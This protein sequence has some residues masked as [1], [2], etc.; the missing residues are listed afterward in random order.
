MPTQTLEPPT[1]PTAPQAPT[2]VTRGHGFLEHTL[3]KLRARKANALIPEPLRQGRILDIGCGSFPYFL[4]TT[5]FAEKHGVDK[6]VN[7]HDA[8]PGVQLRNFD[9]YASDRLPYESG[10]FDAVTML[11]VFEHI[12]VD[13][14]VMLITDIHRVLKPRGVYVMT[15]PAGWTG[16]VLDAL[17]TVGAVSKEEIDEHEDSYSPAKVRAIMQRTPFDPAKTRIGHFELGMNL[18]MQAGR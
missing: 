10:Y 13:R 11:A 8:V 1:A 17:K 6:L 7:V 14:L 3:S 16:P 18:W 15:T 12:R 9:T 2:R 5:R 4:T